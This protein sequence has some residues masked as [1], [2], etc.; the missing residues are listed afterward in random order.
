MQAR[1]DSRL[2]VQLPDWLPPEPS[3]KPA[4]LEAFLAK[5]SIRSRAG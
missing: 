1:Q 4:S 5:V 3:W 2:I